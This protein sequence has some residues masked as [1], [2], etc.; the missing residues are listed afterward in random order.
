MQKENRDVIVTIPDRCYLS[1]DAGREF[2]FPF[3]FRVTYGILPQDSERLS[4]DAVSC[5]EEEKI[6]GRADA[7]QGP[8]IRVSGFEQLL[9]EEKISGFIANLTKE[10]DRW[11]MRKAPEGSDIIMEYAGEKPELDF[12]FSAVTENFICEAKERG[13]VVLKVQVKNFPETDDYSYNLST[14][15]VYAPWAKKISFSPETVSIPAYAEISYEFDGDFVEKRLWQDQTPIETARSP[16]RTLIQKPSQFTLEVFNDRG[17]RDICQ[18]QIDVRPPRI[19]EFRPDREFF[20]KGEAVRLNWELESVCSVS[21]DGFTEGKDVMEENKAVVYPAAQSEEKEVCYILHADGYK[22][23]RS[24]TVSAQITLKETKWKNKGPVSGYFSGNVYESNSYN[25]RLF[26]HEGNV[27]CYAHPKLYRSADGTE[28]EEYAQND[29]CDEE[30]TCLAADYCGGTVY[31]MGKKKDALYFSAYDFTTQKFTCA[32]AG[33]ICSSDTGGFAFSRNR[34]AFFQILPGGIKIL[35]GED[36]QWNAGSSVIKAQRG[37]RVLSGDYCFFKSG[38]YAAMLCTSDSGGQKRLYFYDCDEQME[39]A[40]YVME[41]GAGDCFV[42]LI[43]AE[44]D[45]Y[46]LTDSRIMGCRDGKP[47][48]PY[49]PQVRQGSRP[50]LGRGNDGILMGIYPDKNRWNYGRK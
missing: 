13:P 17:I 36:G 23:G 11:S 18:A 22:N 32:P 16:Y 14:S 6:P 27:Y 49:C 37:M 38:F 26:W 1:P 44:N 12:C 35:Y 25:S 41:P 9:P 30:F 28:W 50:W 29:A 31:M 10:G 45:L 8:E 24:H 20:A 34:T 42:C 4:A 48:D 19:L 46:L 21:L 33:Q 43:P 15:A 2:P 3:Y 40:K 5:T 7:V 39:E 47:A